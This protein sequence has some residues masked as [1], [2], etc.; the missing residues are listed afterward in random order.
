MG[1]TADKSILYSFFHN[2][3]NKSVLVK[4]QLTSRTDKDQKMRPRGQLVNYKINMN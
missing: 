4:N 1:C 3:K 2:N